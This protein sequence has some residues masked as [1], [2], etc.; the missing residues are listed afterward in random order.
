[1]LV[2]S[3]YKDQSIYIGDDIVVTIVDVRGDR[4]RLGV[5]APPNVPVHRQEIYEEIKRKKTSPVEIP[6]PRSKGSGRTDIDRNGFTNELHAVR[7][8]YEGAVAVVFGAWMSNS[9]VR[10]LEST[11]QFGLEWLEVGYSEEQL[12]R[13]LDDPR[14]RLF[15]I[16]EQFCTPSVRFTQEIQAAGKDVVYYNQPILTSEKLARAIYAQIADVRLLAHTAAARSAS[17]V[18]TSAPLRSRRV[19]AADHEGYAHELRAPSFE[20]VSVG[21]VNQELPMN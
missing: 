11:L 4:I 16:Q 2:L 17:A 5:E 21:V 1:M 10:R 8:F 7:E 6:E 20:D 15:I 18:G 13:Y 3:R 19:A 9:A 14:V 12:R